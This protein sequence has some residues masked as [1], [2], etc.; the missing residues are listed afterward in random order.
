MS[1]SQSVPPLAGRP[2]R[3]PSPARGHGARASRPPAAR[4][5]SARA[6]SAL[7]TF[8]L[9]TSVLAVLSLAACDAGESHAEAAAASVGAAR[10]AVAPSPSDVTLPGIAPGAT[11]Y[12]VAPALPTGRIAGV[13]RV[14]API[15]A[16]TTVTL[17]SLA[18]RAC[19]TPTLVDATL[20]VPTRRAGADS[21]TAP[22]GG[23]VVW[24]A[25]ARSGKPLPGERRATLA[26]DRCALTPR[27]LAT[28]AGGT[29][30]V[31]GRDP[32]ASRLRLAR[33]PGGAVVLD[34]RF[35]DAGQVIPSPSAL[36]TAGAVEARG[37]DHPWLRA[38]VLAFDHPY[39]ATTSADGRFTLDAVPPGTY[40]L[41]AWHERLGRVER[42]VTV[43]EGEAEILF[44]GRR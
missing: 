30:L 37:L 25:D 14:R 3:S 23:V 44:E 35:S 6:T 4:P 5:A 26:L 33:Q 42:Q 39:F 18:A 9:A 7:A 11:P 2:Q 32:M 31:S 41:V 38:W 16:D 12:A 20:D 13:V 29:L 34:A 40:T 28:L 27:A 17:D 19:R 21:G 15:P 8:A 1:S 24:L 36:A 22:V 10:A 43:G